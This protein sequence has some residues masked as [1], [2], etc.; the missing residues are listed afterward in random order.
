MTGGNSGINIETG[1][2]DCLYLHSVLQ[3]FSNSKKDRSA[4]ESKHSF[5]A[6]LELLIT[7]RYILTIKINAGICP[8]EIIK[9]FNRL[10]GTLRKGRIN[11]RKPTTHH[12]C[13]L[14]LVDNQE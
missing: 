5:E 12:T 1:M 7:S 10:K 3:Y 6:H 4:A 11:K 9:D 2:F 8:W 13:S 14:T